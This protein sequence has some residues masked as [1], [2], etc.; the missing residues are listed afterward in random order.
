MK[1]KKLKPPTKWAD[2][3]NVGESEYRAI[4]DLCL[5]MW[6]QEHDI[7]LIRGIL[8][9]FRDTANSILENGTI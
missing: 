8:K 2:P 1:P 3:D 5:D 4:H 7:G 6:H 9:Q